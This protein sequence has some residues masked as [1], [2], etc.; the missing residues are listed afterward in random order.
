MVLLLTA[1]SSIVCVDLLLQLADHLNAEIVAGTITN[2]QDALDYLTWTYIYRCPELEVH[3]PLAYYA[4][5]YHCCF[6]PNVTFQT[7]V[8]RFGD[9]LQPTTI[10]TYITHQPYNHC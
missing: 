5:L 2:R 1:N 6:S 3:T 7:T 8:V 10:A 9:R 4:A